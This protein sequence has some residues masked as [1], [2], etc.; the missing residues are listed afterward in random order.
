MANAPLLGPGWGE[1]LP[2]ICPTGQ[3]EYF[4]KR[5]LTEII[6]LPVGH[7]VQSVA[8]MNVTIFGIEMIGAA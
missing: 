6:D 5:G 1:L 4:L 3:E 2:V 7:A 8:R